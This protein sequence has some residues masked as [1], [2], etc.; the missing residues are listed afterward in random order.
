MAT[1]AD[2]DPA[3]AQSRLAVRLHDVT[4]GLAVGIG[5]LKGLKQS[6]DAGP[7][8]DCDGAIEAFEAVLTDLKQLAPDSTRAR[9][10]HRRLGLGDLL[11]KEARRIG[12]ALDLEIVGHD[13]W[14]AVDQAELLR[15]AGREAMRNVKRHSGTTKCRMTI[16]LSDCPFLLTARDWG[17]GI[18]PEAMVGAGIGGLRE[19]ASTMGCHLSIRSQP[20]LGT[21]LVLTGRGCPH[22]SKRPIGREAGERLL[23]SVV[24]EESLSSRRR[25][26]ARGPIAAS[27]QQIT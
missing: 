3:D 6:G 11:D 10:R 21:E 18:G 19:L 4:A 27:D 24:A 8:P 20:G 23:R 17:A 14:L 5:L 26:A 16:D 15:L 7:G 9:P 13:D 1:G 12:L 2:R 25:V 22:N